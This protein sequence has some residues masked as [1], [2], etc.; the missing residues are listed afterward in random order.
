MTI[1]DRLLN[2]HF[3][4]FGR[5]KIEIIE[6][7]LTLDALELFTGG[8]FLG[9]TDNKIGQNPPDKN[10]RQK[11]PNKTPNKDKNPL[12]VFN[13]VLTEN[14]KLDCSDS[15][16]IWHVMDHTRQPPLVS[17]E[18]GLIKGPQQDYV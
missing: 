17:L 2:K 4:W 5:I 3:P 12:Y 13:L 11:I 15:Y 16:F 9:G 6:Q 1:R 18:L 14:K 7:S 8:V 10:L